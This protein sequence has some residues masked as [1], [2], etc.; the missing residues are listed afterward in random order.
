MLDTPLEK[1]FADGTFKGISTEM[2]ERHGISVEIPTVPMARKGKADI[3]QKRWVVERTIRWA[4]AN[5]R[6][7]RDCERNIE[8]A[9]AFIIIGNIKR[10]AP[11]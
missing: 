3:Q 1:V 10:L 5:R 11:K 9:N 4:I 8:H 7:S 2:P 6:F